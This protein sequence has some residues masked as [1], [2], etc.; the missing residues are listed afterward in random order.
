M[1]GTHNFKIMNI[2]FAL[3]LFLLLHSFIHFSQLLKK[4]NF[5]YRIGI[6]YSSQIVK[7]WRD[8][9]SCNTKTAIESLI[10]E[11]ISEWIFHQ[12]HLK[13]L[14]FNYTY[15]QVHHLSGTGK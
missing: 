1:Q 15:F 5:N 12:I 14:F 7:A 11:L 6:A 8:L 10:I 4:E 9:G 3:H 2:V 13:K